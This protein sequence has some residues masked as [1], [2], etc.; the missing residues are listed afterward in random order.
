MISIYGDIEPFTAKDGSTIRELIHPRTHGNRNQSLAEAEV[1]PGRITLLHRHLE[2][3]EIYLFI[4]GEGRMV[5][6][7]DRL[8]V[9]QGDSVYIAP[10]T[11]HCVQN[12]G[13]I[14]LRLLCACSPAY[15]DEDTELLGTP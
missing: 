2:S 11:P 9:Y 10:G 8:E 1:A 13:D 12:T 6:G 3:E 7:Q 15:S 4:Q 14:P 5:L